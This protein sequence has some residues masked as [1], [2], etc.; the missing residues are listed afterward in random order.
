MSL[1]LTRKPG[2]KIIINDDIVI[3]VLGVK[4]GQVKIGIEAPKSV[5]VHREEIHKK[6]KEDRKKEGS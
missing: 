4:Q 2:T 6:I 5:E 1:I 3:T